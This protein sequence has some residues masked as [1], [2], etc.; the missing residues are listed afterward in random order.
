MND[1]IK[2]IAALLEHQQAQEKWVSAPIDE[3]QA[4]S[5][6]LHCQSEQ[7]SQV[8]RDLDSASGNMADTVRKSVSTA[9]N[10]VKQDLKKLD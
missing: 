9:S 6:Q 5:A 4:A 3:Y 8:I 1:E 10:K 7:L 2:Q